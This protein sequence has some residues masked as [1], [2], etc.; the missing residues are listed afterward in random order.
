[1][2]SRLVHQSSSTLRTNLSFRLFS[3]SSPAMAST[4]RVEKQ[5]EVA[6]VKIDLP[7]TKENVLNKALSTDMKATFEKLQ[8]DDSVKSIV[9]MSGKP[10]SFV[11]GADIQMLKAE[12]TAA[13]IEA[14]SRDGQEQFFRIEKS[15]KP[16]VAAIMGSCMGGGLELALACHYRIAVNDK[17]TQLAVPEVML[18]LLPGAGGTQR[19]PK[20]TTVQNV[21]DLTLT[22]KKIKADK[23]K[24]IGIVDHVIQPL[25]DGLGPAAENTH[26]YLEEVAVKTAKDLAEGK[27][28]VNRDK[29]FM[30]KATQ[31]VMTNSLFL[32]NVVLKMA[33]DKL[34]KLTAGNYPAPLK[35]LD[36]VRTAYVDPK[37]GYE[38]EAKAFGELS[39]TFQSKALIG[40][41]DGSTDA[42]K[43]K[44][45]QGLPV[46]EIAV[47]GAGLMGA[48]IANVTIDKGVRTVLLDAN[49]AGVE[50]GQNQILTHLN[51]QMKRRKINKLEKERIYNHLVPT[52]DYSA[53]KNADVVIE[54]VFEDLQLKHKVIKQIESVVGPKTIIASNTSA[55]PIKDIAAASSRPDKVIG[56][57]YFSPVEKMQ[58]LEII[59]HEGT[60]KETLATAAQLGLKQGKLVVVVKDCP[61]FFVVRCLGPMMSEVVRLLQE[62]VS[63]TE[64]DKLTTKFGFPVGAATLADE[65]GLDVAEH[66]AQFLG[67]ALGPRVRGGSADLLSE[68]VNAGYKGRKTGKGIFEYGDGKKG[69]KKV[70][71]EATKLLQKYKLTPNA[72]VSSPEDRQLRLVSRFVNEALLCLE[73]GVLA[74]PSDGDI[75]SVFG[76]G[77]PPFWGGPFRFVDLYGADKLVSSMEKFAGAYESAQFA[78]CQLLKDH[79]KSGKK[80]Y[81]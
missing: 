23:A 2:L 76:I 1:M 3:Q 46:N 18:G 19:L 45:G 59:T 37:K 51:G 56:M 74:S 26:K 61:G 4:L 48:G 65:V 13:G 5:G 24:K 80:F 53:M 79:A 43:N 7:N 47:V 22:G 70:N 41:F 52:I 29:G 35:I 9:V 68:L 11:A 66:V 31:A 44:Y 33:K 58:L 64:L 71:D 73:E 25:G 63:P 36:V 34:M 38:A 39:Q 69:S 81:N 75:A 62:G 54:A 27:L 8:A 32:D 6:V 67:K 10:N 28:K 30:H 17:K 57:H 14:L 20:L 42:K 77:F 55:L 50:R 16:V 72:S 78:P 21:L 40:L 15:Q 49:Q 12:K 60:S